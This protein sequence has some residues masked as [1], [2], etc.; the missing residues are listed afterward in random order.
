MD[1]LI[2]TWR[3]EASD[4]SSALTLEIYARKLERERETGRAGDALI[5]GAWALMGTNGDPA[6]ALSPVKTTEGDAIPL[7]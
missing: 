1:D 4:S 3:S 7:R 5:R 6:A 2:H